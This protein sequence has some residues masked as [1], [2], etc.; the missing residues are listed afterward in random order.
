[1]P[2]ILPGRR[3]IHPDIFTVHVSIPFRVDTILDKSDYTFK[4]VGLNADGLNKYGRHNN[5]RILLS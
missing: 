4:V 5:S 2:P 3:Q 1:M